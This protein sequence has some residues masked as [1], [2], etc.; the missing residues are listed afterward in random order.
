MVG[1][2]LANLQHGGDR[3]SDEI[4]SA[5]APLISQREAAA[6]LNVGMVGARLANLENGQRAASAI[7]LAGNPVTQREAA[8]SQPS[9]PRFDIRQASREYQFVNGLKPYLQ[10]LAEAYGLSRQGLH[11]IM[12]RNDLTKLDLL[13]PDIV[14]QRL[15]G[16]GRQSPLRTR[17]SNPATRETITTKISNL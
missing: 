6:M 7:A 16:L 14:F 3:K 9:R 12:H 2:R 15:L 1:A 10:D 5:I 11:K 17:L 8:A 13:N 4:K